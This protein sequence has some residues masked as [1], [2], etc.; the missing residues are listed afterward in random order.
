VN[1]H[2]TDWEQFA[3]SVWQQAKRRALE[4]PELKDLTRRRYRDPKGYMAHRE[5]MLGLTLPMVMAQQPGWGKRLGQG[6]SRSLL[7]LGHEAMLRQAPSYWL[8][9]PL[10]EAF[11][12]SDLPPQVGELRQVIPA[13]ILFLPPGLLTPDSE[14]L[15]WV[16]FLHLRAGERIQTFCY[17][18]CVWSDDSNP[19]ERIC[20]A[21]T[22]ETTTTYSSTFFPVD[23]TAPDQRILIEGLE[24]LTPDQQERER[25]FARRVD[26][27]VL[28]T[29]L[30]VQILPELMQVGGQVG[31]A[32]TDPSRHQP[33]KGELTW[34]NPNWIGQGYRAPTERKPPQGGSHASP[35][36][37]WRRG[38]YKRVPI[39]RR[40]EGRRKWI[41]VQPTL[42]GARS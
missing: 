5:A 15:R 3:K 7:M 30:A 25:Q 8:A 41:W 20:W 39:G 27:L 31:F 21:A 18:D 14:P 38:H 10:F 16:I 24:A 35:V 22:T 2:S 42:V 6:S 40:D 1:N 4:S 13:G 11:L 17:G 36:C 28:Q 29:L 9:Q 32:K 26:S 19:P 23:E 33:R 34:A 12:K 37:H